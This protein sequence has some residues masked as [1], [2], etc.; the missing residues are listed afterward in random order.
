MADVAR[1]KRSRICDEYRGREGGWN[2]QTASYWKVSTTETTFA[3]FAYYGHNTLAK[4]VLQ[5]PGQEVTAND[6]GDA[7]VR[8]YWGGTGVSP[9]N[10]GRMVESRN[11]SNQ[12]TYQY[13]WGS[14]GELVWAE[15][16]GDPTIGN[17][18][19]PDVEA[20]L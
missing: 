14:R 6:G 11:G 16:N 3:T 19:T 15:K 10:G 2:R 18:S 13:L 1:A 8:S 12:T 5:Y 17:D 4:K 9:V 7:E 20:E